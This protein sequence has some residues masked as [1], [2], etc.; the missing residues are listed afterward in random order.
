MDTNNIKFAAIQEKLLNSAFKFPPGYQIVTNN[1]PIER[2][3]DVN[4]HSN[5]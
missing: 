2:G 4:A 3:R 5:L 1:R